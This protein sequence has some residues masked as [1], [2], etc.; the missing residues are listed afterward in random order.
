MKRLRFLDRA[1]RAVLPSMGGLIVNQSNLLRVRAGAWRPDRI[2]QCETWMA[3]R[4]REDWRRFT[5][6]MGCLGN[7]HIRNCPSRTRSGH[8]DGL[9]LLLR[10]WRAAFW[11]DSTLILP[12][13]VI[14]SSA[15][16]MCH[17]SIYQQSSKRPVACKKGK[18]TTNEHHAGT[19]DKDQPRSR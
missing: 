13:V 12:Q 5:Q 14:T 16:E 19:A 2:L 3:R 8:G 6:G 15:F 10:D 7:E 17:H 1:S 4:F 11:A 9:F 18:W